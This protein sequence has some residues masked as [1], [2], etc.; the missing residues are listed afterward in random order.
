MAAAYLT[1]VVAGASH[2]RLWLPVVVVSVGAFLALAARWFVWADSVPVFRCPR[3][4]GAFLS[5]VPR[6]LSEFLLPPNDS[7]CQA[8]GLKW[9]TPKSSATDAREGSW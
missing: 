8:C 6:A 3:C 4:G 7:S 1:A 2:P 5:R 9:G